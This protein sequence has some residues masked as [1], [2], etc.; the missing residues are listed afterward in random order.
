[1]LDELVPL[2]EAD[3]VPAGESDAYGKPRLAAQS[4]SL[5][6]H[7]VRAIEHGLTAGAH[8]LP[9]IGSCDW[10]DGMNRVGNQGKGES[11]W[12]GF[13]LY[14]V[15][16]DYAPLAEARGDA[17]RAA[18][19]RS[20][21]ERLAAMLELSWD[22]GWYRRAY[23]DDGTPLGS[24]Q[25]V[26]GRIDSLPQSWAVISGAAPAARAE[27]ALDAV[28]A[29]L[30]RREPRVILLLD[31]PFD[32]GPE[33]PGYIK[34]YVPGVRENGG[35]YT[36]AAQ[37]VVMAVA[38]VGQ[39]D[40]AVELFHMLN[41]INHTRTVRD[42]E[43]YRTEPYV[44]AGDVYD[45]PQHKGRGGWTWY[46]GS[47]GWMY[48]VG[49]EEILGIT[50]HGTTLVVKPCIPTSWPGY[51]VTLRLPSPTSPGG[52]VRY[53]IEVENSERRTTGVA[54]AELDG[55][56]VPADAIPLLEDGKEHRVRIV[57]GEAKKGRRGGAAPKRELVASGG[58]DG[59]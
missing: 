45:H 33:N 26:D 54:S 49:L 8:G 55:A 4:V 37:W 50:R 58:R 12:L 48:R 3:P 47:A 38:R 13:F 46:T 14:L 22:G 39:G 34:G 2:L 29:H 7:G 30:V 32:R 27:R 21:A 52:I 16:R 1:V 9:L 31:P 59:E 28:R 17:P 57:M 19:W 25:N 6:E 36:H 10:N 20:E 24:S 56:P 18:R 11:V 35:Q 40:E 44:L 41:P 5:S 43:R 23:F 51:R 15:L 42:V 53:A